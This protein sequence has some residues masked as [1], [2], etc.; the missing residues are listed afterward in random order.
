MNG[1]GGL[2]SGFWGGDRGRCDK[3]PLS[4]GTWTEW[5]GPGWPM[6]PLS[7]DHGKQRV[8]KRSL[9][10]NSR[11]FAPLSSSCARPRFSSRELRAAASHRASL[12][13]LALGDGSGSGGWKN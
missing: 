12:S 7:K 9:G 6:L 2:S 11:G 4:Y 3:G 1:R 8:E 5:N 13:S 10:I